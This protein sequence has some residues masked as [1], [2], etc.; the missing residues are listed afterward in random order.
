MN[1]FSD[2]LDDN[3]RGAFILTMRET[4]SKEFGSSI[5]NIWF[6][7][8]NFVSLGEF[9]ATLSFP[10]SFTRDYVKREY[11]NGIAKNKN[12]GEETIWLR[13]GLREI[14][15]E[16]FPKLLS[17]ELIVE[18][19]PEK[20]GEKISGGEAE[21]KVAS[22]SQND[23]LYN[24]GIDLNRNYVFNNFVV[25]K[26]NKTA[27]E[28]MR[29]LSLDDGGEGGLNPLFLYG[30][31]GV[32][33]TH[34]CQ[35]LAWSLRENFP[36]KNI[37][38]ISAEKF[39]Y[40][41]VQSCK[42]QNINN[43]KTKFRNVDCL[44]VDDLQFILG[45]ETTQREFFYTFETLANENKRVMLACDR[46]P[47][48]LEGLDK[49][50]KSRLGGG[51]I[52]NIEENDDETA[53]NIA[54]KKLELLNL[55][56]SDDLIETV[57]ANFRKDARQLEGFLRRLRMNETIMGV[58]TTAEVIKEFLNGEK[59]E[60]TKTLTMDSILDAASKYFSIDKNDL[61][62]EKKL[63]HLILPRHIAMYLSKKLINKS[64]GEIAEKF[65]KK[66]HATALYAYNHI[67]KLMENGEIR[68]IVEEIENFLTSQNN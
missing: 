23:N 22:M 49:K 2:G 9:E 20:N 16:F 62:S 5:Y 11:L 36:K 37:L 32:G 57:A 50:L 33:K 17:L 25:G 21:S 46:S 66:N 34:L 28:T 51:L 35:A 59:T 56:L 29:T 1:V 68:K 8:M 26:S 65:N 58:K 47:T 60:K 3:Q 67:K 64:S 4:L 52:V 55:S 54:K 42:N 61:K 31:V 53:V 13:K 45:K 19:R 14:L 63:K 30:P 39:M 12:N 44:I 18:N 7:N 43:F 41:F 38:Y 15:M 10:N 24:I 6:K 48:R 27:F 40:L